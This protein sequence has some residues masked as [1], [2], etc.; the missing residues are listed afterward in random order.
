[1]SS[2]VL[3]QVAP[4]NDSSVNACFPQMLSLVIMPRSLVTTYSVDE[5]VQWALGQGPVI[6]PQKHCALFL[7]SVSPK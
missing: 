6:Y 1:M 2:V 5:V 3:A 7:H 4:G